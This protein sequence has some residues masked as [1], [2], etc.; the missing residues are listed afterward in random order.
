ML[1]GMARHITNEETA[2]CLLR[3]VVNEELDKKGNR[4]FEKLV[5]MLTPYKRL[6]PI[7]YHPSFATKVERIQK[8]TSRITTYNRIRPFLLN[9]ESSDDGCG[10]ELGCACKAASKIWASA[11]AYYEVCPR[12]H[13]IRIHTD[14]SL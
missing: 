7:T 10:H 8:M 13:Q 4:M 3:H 2:L 9:E 5:E 12:R 14:I 11:N 6:H 1:S